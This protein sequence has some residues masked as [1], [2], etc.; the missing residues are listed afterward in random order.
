MSITRSP[1]YPMTRLALLQENARAADLLAA[2]RAEE[3]GDQSVHQL[4]V[5]RQRGCRLLRRIK[6]LFLV[7][8]AVERRAGASVDED[9]LRRQ[10]EAFP[11]DVVALRDDAAAAERV[12]LLDVARDPAGALLRREQD[13]AGDDQRVLILLAD[14]PPVRGVGEEPFVGLE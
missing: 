4:E 3:A 7:L 8:L 1:D 10:Q 11:V 13:R 9:E 6:D 5:R 2:Q 14:A 12:E